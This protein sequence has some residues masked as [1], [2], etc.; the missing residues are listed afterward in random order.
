MATIEKAK[1]RRVEQ[2]PSGYTR[3]LGNADLGNLMSRVQG[4]VITSGTELEKMIWDRVKRISDFDSFLA[5][6]SPTEWPG[7]W[8]ARKTQIKTSKYIN[9]QYEPDFLAFDLLHHICYV[10][11]IKDGDQFDTKKSHSEFVALHGFAD[12]VKY[13]LPLDLQVRICCFNAGARTDAYNG[14]KRKFPMGEILTGS[15]LCGLFEISY[16]SITGTRHQDQQANLAYFID[17]LLSIDCV[18]RLVASSLCRLG[19]T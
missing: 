7:V 11:E 13:T 9:A 15:E 19:G 5:M 1:G 14:L 8:V 18:R 2:A 16:S 10:V 12:S 3:L 17:E 6:L 4:A